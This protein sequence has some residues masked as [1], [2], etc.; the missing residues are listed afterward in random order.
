MRHRFLAL[1]LERVLIYFRDS[2]V[3]RVPRANVVPDK[4]STR[5]LS[6]PLSRLIRGNSSGFRGSRIRIFLNARVSLTL[7]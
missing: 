7:P 3:A 2:I 4:L 6:L 1:L 5:E